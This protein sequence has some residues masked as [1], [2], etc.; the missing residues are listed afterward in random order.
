MLLQIAFQIAF[1]CDRLQR[2]QILR[3]HPT[4]HSVIP[5]VLMVRQLGLL[6][7]G[8]YPCITFRLLDLQVGSLP[9]CCLDTQ[10]VKRQ[11]VF[12]RHDG[13]ECSELLCGN[14]IA[15]QLVCW[16]FESAVCH[17]GA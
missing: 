14:T 12:T 2:L 9:C 6:P 11:P 8:T 7:N 13:R 17:A 3:A 16:I 5:G 10:R 15:S 4:V 1:R